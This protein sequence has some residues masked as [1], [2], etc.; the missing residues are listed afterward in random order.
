MQNV[1][2]IRHQPTPWPAIWPPRHV[3]ASIWQSIWTLQ[4]RPPVTGPAADRTRLAVKSQ[5]AW[6]ALRSWYFRNRASPTPPLALTQRRQ[7]TG[8]A[9]RLGIGRTTTTSRG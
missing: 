8:V 4:Q 2:P 9:V 1:A 6:F 7:C 5:L 3:L